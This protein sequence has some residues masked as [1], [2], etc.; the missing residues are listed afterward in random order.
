MMPYPVLLAYKN[1]ATYITGNILVT[2]GGHV[3]SDHI[4]IEFFPTDNT[5]MRAMVVKF[6]LMFRS[7]IF[8]V[9]HLLTD[10]TLY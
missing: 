2:M 8:S 10:T 7:L 3:S 9:K 6:K 5:D 4:F 1:L